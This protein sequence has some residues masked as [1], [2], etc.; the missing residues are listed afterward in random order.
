MQFS[1]PWIMLVRKGA[2]QSWHWLIEIELLSVYLGLRLNSHFLRLDYQTPSVNVQNN[3]FCLCFTE[4]NRNQSYVGCHWMLEPQKSLRLVHVQPKL[5]ERLVQA[6][7]KIFCP[8]LSVLKKFL[9][10]LWRW[11]NQFRFKVKKK[12]NKTHGKLKT[13]R[14]CKGPLEIT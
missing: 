14:V 10:F 7:W 1:R 13:H 6:H 5:A 2:D 3:T 12:K 4:N 9:Y 8:S 11:K